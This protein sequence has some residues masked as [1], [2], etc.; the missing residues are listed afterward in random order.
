MIQTCELN[1]ADARRAAFAQRFG[2]TETTRT[3]HPLRVLGKRPGW[4]RE[5]PPDWTDHPTLWR[6][7]ER[8]VPVCYQ[9]QPYNWT[10]EKAA[11]VAA[12][13]AAHGLRWGWTDDPAACWWN[14]PHT[15]SVFLWADDAAL[16]PALLAALKKEPAPWSR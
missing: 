10:P 9:S 2:L 7:P 5:F 12:Y 11:A 8:R 6:V 15:V 14:H 4:W 1:E 13:A 3:V 16:P